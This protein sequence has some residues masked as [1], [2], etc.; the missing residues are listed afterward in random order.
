MSHVGAALKRK[1]KK[2]MVKYIQAL[3]FLTFF[4]PLLA[5]SGLGSDP[6][7]ICYLGSSCG[8]EGTL[9]HCAGIEPTSQGSRDTANLIVSQW[10]LLEF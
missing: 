6:S 8:Y 10:E 2:S 7:H 4:S 5:G 3:P 9:T 1:K